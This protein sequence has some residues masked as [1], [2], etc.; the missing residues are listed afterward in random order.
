MVRLD[1]YFWDVKMSQNGH[2]LIDDNIMKEMFLEKCYSVH[3]AYLCLLQVWKEFNLYRHVGQYL[4]TGEVW[5]KGGENVSF[6]D[7]NKLEADI[8]L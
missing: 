7:E 6:Q 2:F 5:K 4:M 3:E 8:V 1:E